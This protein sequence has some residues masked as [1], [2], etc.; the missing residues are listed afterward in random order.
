[1]SAPE[2]GPAEAGRPRWRRIARIVGNSLVALTLVTLVALGVA[3]WYEATVLPKSEG[4]GQCSR[5][6]SR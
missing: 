2:A 1:M 6:R 4:M 5:Y 3:A